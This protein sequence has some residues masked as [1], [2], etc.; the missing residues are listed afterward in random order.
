MAMN[1]VGGEQT[2]SRRRKTAG[3]RG[4]RCRVWRMVFAAGST[5]LAERRRKAARKGTPA[6]EEAAALGERSWPEK[7]CDGGEARSRTREGSAGFIGGDGASRGRNQRGRSRGAR[8]A[9]SRSSGD[10]WSREAEDVTPAERGKS[11][12]R[13]KGKEL[14]SLSILDEEREDGARGRERRF[15]RVFGRERTEQR[16]R[17]ATGHGRRRR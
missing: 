16:G 11:R 10:R 4:G 1:G 2:G 17:A 7:R 9:A 8:L 14:G 6:T 3:L 5:A 13:G 15:L 12:K